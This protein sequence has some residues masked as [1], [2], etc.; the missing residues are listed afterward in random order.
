MD[1]AIC[2]EKHKCV[3]E[4]TRCE[5]HFCSSCLYQW[6]AKKHTCALCRGFFDLR[7]IR[8]KT[9]S[10][11]KTRSLKKLIKE[12]E[13][14]LELALLSHILKRYHIYGK[15]TSCE[16]MV[17]NILTKCLDNVDIFKNSTNPQIK[18]AIDYMKNYGIY[19]R[20]YIYQYK[21]K[22]YRFL[23]EVGVTNENVVISNQG[24]V[25]I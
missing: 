9:V 3:L 15:T 22:Y 25:S 16:L 13:L 1:C 4:I 8:V 6:Y 10:G 20:V 21:N 14:L 18:T 23:N 19:Y 17:N 7:G 24:I 12:E 11:V 2:Q 5:H